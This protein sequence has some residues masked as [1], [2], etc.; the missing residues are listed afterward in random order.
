MVSIYFKTSLC[1]AELL[2]VRDKAPLTII[3]IAIA[4][5]KYAETVNKCI[6]LRMARM[7]MD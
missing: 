6:W 4:I 3:I 5:Y 2:K 7:E 1:A